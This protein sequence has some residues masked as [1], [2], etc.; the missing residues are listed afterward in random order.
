MTFGDFN[1]LTQ[2]QPLLM[3]TNSKEESLA[4]SYTLSASQLSKATTPNTLKGYQI[5]S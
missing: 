1:E 2:K 3:S 4:E 5:L